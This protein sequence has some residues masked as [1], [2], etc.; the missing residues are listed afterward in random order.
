MSDELTPA[1]TDD[2]LRGLGGWLRL[3]GFGFSL[4]VVT[5]V[6]QKSSKEA[7]PRTSRLAILRLIGLGPDFPSFDLFW[8]EME[9]AGQ[10]LALPLLPVEVA[11]P[12]QYQSAFT[13]ISRGRANALITIG[14]FV[15]TTRQRTQIVELVLRHRLPAIYQ[16]RGSVDLGGLMSYGPNRR[17]NTARRTPHPADAA[18]DR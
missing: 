6:V 13:A 16:G 14:D 18:S 1:Y 15:L 2:E 8:K 7:F 4:S 10:A 12:D 5:L 9:R 11:G 3:A 17:A